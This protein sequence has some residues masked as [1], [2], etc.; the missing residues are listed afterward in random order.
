MIDF[1]L[2]FIE[3]V[4]FIYLLVKTR[5]ALGRGDEDLGVFSF[6]QFSVPPVVAPKHRKQP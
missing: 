2:I 1:L 3:L 5:Q 6:K 4:A